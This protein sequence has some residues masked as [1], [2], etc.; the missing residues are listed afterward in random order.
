MKMTDQRTKTYLTLITVIASALLA[1]MA[2]PEF[3]QFALADLP[4][5]PTPQPTSAPK[6]APTGGLIELHVQFP[7]AISYQ[8][9]E[10]WTVVQW[11]DEWGAWRDVAG[12]QGELEDIAIGEVGEVIGKRV[13]WLTEADMGKG[14]FRWQV[15]RSNGGALLVTSESF[16]LP[17]IKGQTRVV[18][19][20]L[21]P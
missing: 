14:L 18:E 6:P 21:V 17:D 16:Y 3:T 20:S 12:W 13:W 4:P 2:L 8:W 5:R 11:Q 1:A 9:Q 10:L 7:K 19:V 15:Y